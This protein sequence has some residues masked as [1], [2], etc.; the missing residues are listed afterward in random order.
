MLEWYKI[1][2]PKKSK[3]AKSNEERERL[4]GLLA[5]AIGSRLCSE[6][7]PHDLLTFIN[8]GAGDHSPWTRRRWNAVLQRPFNYATRLGLI[9]KNPF[10]GLTFPEGKDG[11]DWTDEEYQTLLRLANPA[12]RRVLIFIRFSGM[13]PGEVRGLQWEN[14]KPHAGAIILDDHKTMA[15]T[16][17]LHRIPLSKILLKFL[18]VLLSKSETGTGHVFLNSYGKPW[19]GRV[20]DDNFRTLRRRAGLPP[21]VKCHGGRHF[22]A[23]QAII[24]GVNVCESVGVAWP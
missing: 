17:M 13:R 11:R 19:K 18:T 15:K 24:N 1:N 14:V 5:A 10:W 22:F 23:T 3:C 9:D 8:V 6:C 20:F 7:R 16:K 21:E 2:N 4:F 12:M